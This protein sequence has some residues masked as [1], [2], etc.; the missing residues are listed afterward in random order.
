[1]AAVRSINPKQFVADIQAGVSDVD[2]MHKYRISAEGVRDALVTLL[3]RG[4]I[5][6][7]DVHSWGLLFSKAV[8]IE[9]IRLITRENVTLELSVYEAGRP[10][11]RGLV[12]NVSPN[13]LAVRGL[14]SEAAAE[15]VLVMPLKIAPVAVK[16]RCK[17]AERTG[18][19]TYVAGFEIVKVLKGDW[20]KF[21]KAIRNHISKAVAGAGPPQRVPGPPPETATQER[22]AHSESAVQE[23]V[24][25]EVLTQHNGLAGKPDG[26]TPSVITL[27]MIEKRL[28]LGELAAMLTDRDHVAFMINPVNFAILSSQQR[29]GM[30]ERVREASDRAL[31][32]LQERSRAF[33]LAL[34]NSA[35]LAQFST[36]L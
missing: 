4:D 10:D 31:R 34:E 9:H 21:R 2:L 19:G 17:W 24:P 6:S 13:G 32:N 29:E 25:Y 11:T 20:N 8:P 23:S 1:M 7:V 28:D 12:A 36:A 18:D 33:Q 35:I 5:G 26:P 27:G 15:K 30:L 14:P 16:A 3:A 22:T